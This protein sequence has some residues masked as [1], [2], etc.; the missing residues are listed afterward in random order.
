M[1]KISPELSLEQTMGGPFWA[2]A[3]YSQMYP[4]LLNDTDAIR[5]WNT[6]ESRYSPADLAL[7]LKLVDEFIALFVLF[8]ARSFDDAIRRYIETHPSATIVDVGCGMD[9]TFSRVDNGQIHWYD[10][11]L[12]DAIAKRRKYIPDAPRCTAITKSV[13]DLGWLESVDFSKDIG[14][15]FLVGGLLYYFK[16]EEVATLIRTMAS[17]F[18]GG[19]LIFDVPSKLG[20][21]VWNR[22]LRKSDATGVSFSFYINDAARQVAEWDPRLQIVDKFPLFSRLP[23]NPKWKRK[24]RLLMKLSDSLGV[25][26]IIQLKFPQSQ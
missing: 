11:D 22:R 20:K 21:R 10:L 8:R 15:L 9:T 16:E 5:I 13:L 25:M 3:T 17:R 6:I 12:P 24:T 2:R 23:H 18:P 19:E 26:K 1:E 14:I 7:V 4:E